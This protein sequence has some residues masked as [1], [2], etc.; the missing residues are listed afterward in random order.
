MNNAFDFKQKNNF[1]LDLDLLDASQKS[2]VSSEEKNI[3]IRASAGSGKTLT[4]INAIANYRYQ[5]INDRICAITYT[6]AA[7]AEMEE[8]LNKMGIYDV[9]VTTIHVWARN[10]LEKFALKYDFKIKIMQENQIKFI[11]QD[12]I[13]LHRV[14]RKPKTKVNLG[15]LYSFV[16]GNKNMDITDSY[17]RVLMTLEDMYKQYKRDNALYDFTD[18]PLY[19]YDV[20]TTYDEYIYDIDALF[21]DE[22]QDVDSIQFELFEKVFARKKFFIGDGWQSIF[23]FRGADGEV[24]NKLEDFSLYKLK[25]NYRSYQEII[26]YACAVYESLLEAVEQCKSCYITNVIDCYP[27]KVKCNK[28]YDGYVYVFSGSLRDIEI[29][30]DSTKELNED[31]QYVVFKQMI[32]SNSMVLCR[33]NKEVKAIQEKNYFNVSTVHQA[34]GLEYDNVIVIDHEMNCKEDLNIAYV[35]LT[36]ARNELLVLNWFDFEYNMKKYKK[37]KLLEV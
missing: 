10:L 32:E 4:L 11:L 18:Y 25:Y 1:N 19:L 24:F 34:K 28:G 3:L 30:N 2:A 5:R 36:R 33:T 16:T 8:R 15:V 27:S 35:A 17:R 23:G 31:D 20:M 37:E 12:L 7:R 13:D 14:K 21:V 22:F 6:R 26:D 29:H 9:E